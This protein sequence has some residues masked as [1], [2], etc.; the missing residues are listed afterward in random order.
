MSKEWPP[1][2]FNRFPKDL[3]A[4]ILDEIPTYDADFEKYINTWTLVS[5]NPVFVS[6]EDLLKTSVW[7]LES[8]P[9]HILDLINK[10]WNLKFKTKKVNDLR[11]DQTLEYAKMDAKTARPSVMINDEISWGSSRWLASLLRGDKG[12]YVWKI[13]AD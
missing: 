3:L 5:E 6:N 2:T 7:V 13:K 4:E 9:Q 11:P 1:Q 8:T 10:K 12:I